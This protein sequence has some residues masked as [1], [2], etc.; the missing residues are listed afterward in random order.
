MLGNIDL[1]VTV[2]NAIPTW[3]T[4]ASKLIFM[5]SL[6][7][8]QCPFSR[9]W[10]ILAWACNRFDWW[11]FVRS[12]WLG[13]WTT[14][15]GVTHLQCNQIDSHISILAASLWRLWM[16]KI[17]EGRGWPWLHISVISLLLDGDDKS[18]YWLLRNY[19][20]EHCGGR[21]SS[22]NNNSDEEL[23]CEE[24]GAHDLWKYEY[25]IEV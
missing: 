15:L 23:V 2:E 7:S 24:K 3:L 12:T 5:P 6:C 9:I 14:Q 18:V 1:Q 25:N 8:L 21:C 11:L 13:L 4:L 17:Y 16:L 20:F 10:A 19:E 22:C